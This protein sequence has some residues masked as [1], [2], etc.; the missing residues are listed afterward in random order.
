MGFLEKFYEEALKN[1]KAKLNSELKSRSGIDYKGDIDFFGAF[2]SASSPEN[3]QNVQKLSNERKQTII[4]NS[5]KSGMST[6]NALNYASGQPLEEQTPQGS[7][8]LDKVEGVGKALTSS[9]DRVGSSVGEALAYGGQ[10]ATSAREAQQRS[11]DMDREIIAKAGQQLKD[12]NVP[13][14]K[15]VR[16]RKLIKTIGGDNTIYEAQQTESKRVQEQ[17]DPVKNVAAI[18]DVGFDVVTLGTVAGA[19]KTANLGRQI[20][21]GAAEGATSGVFGAVEQKGSDTGIK[22][23]AMG[24]GIGAAAGGVLTGGVGKLSQWM[25]DKAAAKAAKLADA[26]TANLNAPI[27]RAANELMNGLDAEA[28]FTKSQGITDPSRLLP[29]GSESKAARLSEIDDELDGLRKGTTDPNAYKSVESELTAM[30]G[31]PAGNTRLTKAGE[32]PNRQTTKVGTFSNDTP[33]TVGDAT[34]TAQRARELMK[35]R[36]QLVKEI[37]QIKNPVNR[38]AEQINLVDSELDRAT[39][40]GDA[41]AVQKLQEQ[42]NFLAK[43]AERIDAIDTHLS[44]G[45]TKTAAAARTE[46]DAIKDG[47]TKG[48]GD[49]VVSYAKE[50]GWLD[51]QATMSKQLID[52]DYEK[53]KRIAMGQEPAPDGLMAS[54]VYEAV[55]RRAK[56]IGDNNLRKL[57]ATESTVPTQ[58][59]EKGRFNAAF[60]YRDK[61][62]PVVALQDIVKARKNSALNIP[63]TVTTEESDR[64]MKMGDALEMT[65]PISAARPTPP[66]PQTPR[67]CPGFA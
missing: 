24:A 47:I 33:K 57:L 50:P 40:S 12:P 21:R 36:Q 2:M 49:D 58:G 16:I 1:K 37:D 65:A 11:I 20:A 38:V 41:V 22:D 30:A 13:E 23:L 7:S 28:A 3:A 26:Q 59:M 61:T 48:Y 27:D 4:N 9:W 34:S 15:K 44:N 25:T 54:S 29:D 66:S 35:E 51:N 45:Q 18:A 10:D 19:A 6:Q 17:L 32:V 42:S 52:Q 55:K 14:E 67:D 31:E 5:L 63:A 46:A 60:A 39:R 43:E 53:A 56:A 64:I 62:D 8:L